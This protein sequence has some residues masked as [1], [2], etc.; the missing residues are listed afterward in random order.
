MGQEEGKVA[1]LGGKVQ[2]CAKRR[3][4]YGTTRQG[5]RQ[6][7]VGGNPLIEGRTGRSESKCNA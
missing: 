6:R 2:E 5:G 3:R 7:L 4:G 1:Y